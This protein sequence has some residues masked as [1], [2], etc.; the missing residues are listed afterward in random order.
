MRLPISDHIDPGSWILEQLTQQLPDVEMAAG[1]RAWYEA[2]S[3]WS[4]QE[5]RLWWKWTTEAAESIGL[6]TKTI[7]CSIGEAV[8]L[9]KNG[10]EIISWRAVTDQEHGGGHWVRI[11]PLNRGR[12]EVGEVDTVTKLSTM[13]VRRLWKLLRGFESEGRVR[14]VVVRTDITPANHELRGL[15]PF[16]RLMALLKP[17]WP[18]LW[19]VIVFA[20]LVGLLMLATPMA[21]EALVNTVAF[22]RFLQ[23]VIVLALIL[24]TFLAFSAAMRGLQ[25]YVAE[26]VQRRLFAR[27]AGDLA[28]RLPRAKLESIDGVYMPELANRFFDIV[29]VQKVAA[30]LMLDGL[31]LILA[32]I[33]GM[34]V[35]GFYHPWLLGFDILMMAS[36]AFIIFILGRGAVSSAVKESKHKYYMASWLEDISRCPTAFRTSGGNDFALERTDR[37]VHEYLEA[38]QKHF[39]ILM[40]QILF[41]LGLQAVASTVLLGL[42]GWLV[43]VGQLTLGQLVAAELIVTVIVGAFAKLGKH[44][45]SFYDLLA[46]V[47]KLGILFDIPTEHHDGVLEGQLEG[48]AS[49]SLSKV[50]YTGRVGDAF[51]DPVSLQ[52]SAGS[53]LAVLGNS[54]SGRST[55]V[56]LI[57]GLRSPTKGFIAIDDMD[58]QDLRPDVLRSQVAA[59]REPEIFHG[60]IEENVHLHRSDVTSADV[61][62]AM[63]I[64][65]LYEHVLRMKTGFDTKLD[66][67]GAP[68]SGSQKDLLCLA[69]AIAGKPRLLLIDGVLDRL[70]D[71][72]LQHVLQSLFSVERQWTVLVTTGRR[73]IAERFEQVIE[74]PD[75]VAESTQSKELNV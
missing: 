67:S 28:F 8:E 45:E 27:V 4:G 66:G 31:G 13:K 65:G 44:M 70:S 73:A 6:T 74:L 15:S 69:R 16:A 9:V 47:D 61:R 38:R 30:Q 60:T 12:F 2:R 39:H 24:L 53:S 41:A 40:R 26:I 64:V 57:Y 52:L 35:L 11:R 25:T 19:I 68:L 43:I 29:T 48:P 49:L 3:A 51:R 50:Q 1:R 46:S 42:G 10:A 18:D 55:L 7:D 14:C 36:I 34:A 33:I 32:A 54:G 75:V 22:G 21:V 37:L 58:P 17:E 5:R 63:E 59:A 20:F 62:H 71:G 56:E 23:P 72:E